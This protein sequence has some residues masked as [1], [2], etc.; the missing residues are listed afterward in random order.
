MRRQLT[1]LLLQD[2]GSPIEEVRLRLEPRQHSRIATHVAPCP[3]DELAAWQTID[4]CR[5]ELATFR[6]ACGPVRRR[7]PQTAPYVAPDPVRRAHDRLRRSVLWPQ[8]K[9]HGAHITLLH[10]R[11]AAGAAYDLVELA[12]DLADI[13]A[14]LRSIAL[15]EQDADGVWHTVHDYRGGHQSLPRL[16]AA[17]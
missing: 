15:I 4:A 14:T 11:H 7:R 2:C 5:R 17:T 6:S 9:P 1:L 10:P 12:Q 8:A 3:D 16:S 13:S